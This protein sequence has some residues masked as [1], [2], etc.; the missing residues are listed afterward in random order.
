MIRHQRLLGLLLFSIVSLISLVVPAPIVAD[1]W[2][3]WKPIDPAQLAMKSPVVEKDAD[4][5]ALFWEVRVADEV[6][7][8]GARIVFR[9]YIRIKIFTE[10]GKE[11]HSTVEIRYGSRDKVTDIAA[12]TIRPDGSILEVKKDAVFDRDLA[13]QGS[14]KL[15]AKA[16]A[17]P[18]VEPGAIIEYRWRE[19]RNDQISFYLRLSFQRN[20]PVHFV[21][22]Y[23]KPLTDVPLGMRTLTFH[24]QSVPL[25]KEK[26]GFFSTTLRNMPAFREEPR[27]PPRDQVSA[28]MLLYYSDNDQTDTDKFWKDY[29]KEVYNDHKAGMRVNDDVRKAAAAAIGDASTPDQ[30]L[31]RLVE[32]C[33][34][35]IK[36]AYDDALGLTEA[37]RAKLKEN[38]SPSDTLKRGIGTTY[39]ISM[40]FAAMASA[41]GFDARFARLSDRSD[42]FFDPKTPTRAFM[43]T[44]DIAVKVGD[45]WRFFDPGSRYV[46]IGMLSWHEEGVQALIS[47]PKEPFF[48]STPISPPEKSLQK[49]SAALRLSEDGTLE[50][51]VRIEYTGQ[52]A[53][54]RKEYNDDDSPSQREETLRE[55]IKER[56]STAQVSQ[57]QIENVTDPVK[58]FIYSFH[59]KVPGYA[60]R[61]GKRL[62]LQPAFFQHGV[63]PMFPT[64][65]RRYPIYFHYPWSESDSVLIALPEGYSVDSGDAPGPF[66]VQQVGSYEPK[67]GLTQDGRTIEYHRDFKFCANNV[68]LLPTASYPNLKQIF[69]VL[70][71]RDNHTLSLKQ[72]AAKQ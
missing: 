35:K 27:M 43:R 7:G 30:K 71:E 8:G 11:A 28:W 37:D 5:E 1:D 4:A 20:I 15:K 46:P 25:V 3:E 72:N 10:R 64:S 19:V 62:F 26:D 52:F 31:D 42:F 6:D 58:P 60:Q 41:S 50:G 32:F 36:N 38:N 61:T 51:V 66:N 29:G 40:L 9:H 16:F 18:G 63:G 69:D 14:E 56:M 48:I 49:R 47:D 70:H 59:I 22:Y 44:Y 23:I 34:S 45:Q 21:K 65:E 2:K 17:M 53:I 33:R 55:M 54:E 39:D 57:I 68:L 12:R 67:L 24:T 13:R